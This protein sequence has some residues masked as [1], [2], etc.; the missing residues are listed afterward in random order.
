MLVLTKVGSDARLNLPW[1][2]LAGLLLPESHLIVLR[3]GIIVVCAVEGHASSIQH[4]HKALVLL[5]ERAIVSCRNAVVPS[6]SALCA[7]N[8]AKHSIPGGRLAARLVVGSKIAALPL[9]RAW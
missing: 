1:A 5:L 4:V 3:A 6:D 7:P 9:R 2:D 8:G